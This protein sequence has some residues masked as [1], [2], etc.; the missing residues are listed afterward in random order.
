MAGCY[1]RERQIVS[2]AQIDPG[3][4][5]VGGS[6]F[7]GDMSATGILVPAF[8]TVSQTTRYFFRCCSFGLG[9][10]Q[11]AYIRSLREFVWLGIDI[12][13]VGVSPGVVH[14]EQIVTTPRWRFPDGNAVFHLRR[15]GAGEEESHSSFAVP[16]VP[17]L[18][19]SITAL[20]DTPNGHSPALLGRIDPVSLLYVPLNGGLPY[21]EGIAGLGTMRDIRHPP[22]LTS[23]QDLD[24]QV[25][26]PGS[27]AMYC[28]VFQTNPRGRIN[29]AGSKDICDGLCAEDRFWV[30]NDMAR[31]WA[32]GAEITFDLCSWDSEGWC[33]EKDCAGYFNPDISCEHRPARQRELAR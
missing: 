30:I 17:G 2:S 13:Q 11:T 31:Y 23:S 26:G 15:V 8:P 16:P 28:S 32:V 9:P 24:L 33:S 22:G 4:T 10:N 7:I 3:L 20:V 18:D 14:F 1:Q 21:G 5:G 27:V 6:P 29:W 12:T 25:T 19:A